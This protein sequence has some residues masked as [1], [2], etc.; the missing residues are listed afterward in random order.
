MVRRDFMYIKSPC[1]WVGNK[2]K[3]LDKINE[4][5]GGKEYE[6]VIEPFMGTGNILLNINAPAEVYIG[7]DNIPLVPR[8]YSYMRDN[9]FYYSLEEL[10]AIIE[11]WNYFSDKEDYYVFRNYWN[12][13]YSNNI[14]DKDFIYETVLLLKM[15]SN[16]MVRFNQKGEFNQGFR[17]LAKGKSEFFSNNMKDSIV[18]QL[19]L[20][21]TALKNKNYKFIVGDF[22]D[23]LKETTENDLIILDPPYILRTDMYDMNFTEEDDA[24]LFDFLAY[25]KSDFLYFNYLESGRMINRKMNDLFGSTKHKALRI[26]NI[27][28]KTMAGQGRKSTKKVKEVIVTNIR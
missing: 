12:S 1:N 22:K 6:R 24:F 25:T 3:H 18:S 13:K 21:S 8:L 2:Y 5:V 28:N 11:S 19:N 16:S 10:E 7:N 15:C 9:D 14:Y 17:G 4:I 23:V 27:S 26:E 20:L